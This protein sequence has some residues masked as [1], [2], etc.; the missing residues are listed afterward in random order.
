MNA[1]SLLL[2]TSMAKKMSALCRKFGI[3]QPTG[4][5]I[6]N[7][8]KELGLNGI[9]DRSRRPYRHA[10][11]LPFQAERTILSIKR[12][13]PS[14]GARKI[15]DKLL[16]EF[17]TF[18]PPAT[19][20]FHAVLDRNGLVGRRK[21]RRDRAEGMPLHDASTPNE[22]W[23]ADYKG[24][25]MLGPAAMTG[26]SVTAV[27]AASNVPVPTCVDRS[28]V[29]NMPRC[30]PASAPCA[31]TESAPLSTSQ[32]ASPNVVAVDQTCP[33]QDLICST[34]FRSGKPKWKLT[35]GVSLLRKE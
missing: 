29:R 12:Q 13:H 7:R 10:N 17:P 8:Y 34:D 33:P 20:T 5:K 11:K 2:A 4:Y 1:F 22:L 30:P 6:I 19:S 32:R 21:R 18:K 3:F 31:I 24:V 27:T 14:C 28:R 9:E 16:K 26:T 35:I 25:L 23:C 15:R